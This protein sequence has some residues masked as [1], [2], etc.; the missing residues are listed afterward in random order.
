MLWNRM[1]A[2][3]ATICITTIF[4]AGCE[5]RTNVFIVPNGF[6]G[7]I[8]IE[9]SVADQDALDQPEIGDGKIVYR[10]PPSGL[11]RLRG[12]GHSQRANEWKPRYADGSHLATAPEIWAQEKEGANPVDYERTVALWGPTTDHEGNL[13]LYDDTI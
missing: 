6:L 11:L 7:A 8:K 10:I 1:I 5:P 2:C 4:T 9:V 12:P 13:W 3:H